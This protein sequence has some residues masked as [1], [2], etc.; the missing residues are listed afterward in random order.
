MSGLIV[1]DFLV[2]RKTFKSYLLI[3]GLYAALSAMG[4]FNISFVAAFI[5]VMVMLLPI[6]AFAYDEQAGWDRCAMSLPLGR[7]RVVTARYL[8]ILLMALV[9]AA[10]GAAVS[11]IMAIA[12][13]EDMVEMLATIL[14]TVGLGLVVSAILLPLCYKLGAERA[15]PYLYFVLFVP[16]VAIFL[17]YRMG[18][19]VDASA[20]D[21]MSPGALLGFFAL[22]PF[23]GLAV[24]AVSWLISCR[25]AEKKE[26]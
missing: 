9:S 12:K 10:G 4:M 16:M 5:S 20:L 1:K 24:I 26:F 14:T 18:F 25:V 15:R 8:F 3:I 7:R 21:R 22:I 6:S 13:T 2:L 11:V 19:H 23:G 17:A